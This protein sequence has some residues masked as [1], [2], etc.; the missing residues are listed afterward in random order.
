MV[1]QAIES[2]TDSVLAERLFRQALAQAPDEMEIYVA[3]YKFYFYQKRLAQAET[4]A[5]QTLRKVSALTGLPDDWRKLAAD[6]AGWSDPDSPV[7]YYLY[8]M[9]ALA[10]IA[11]RRE[12]VTLAQSI[13]DKLAELDPQDRVGG[14]VIMD[15]A[16]RM[17]EVDD[18]A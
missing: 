11:L 14:S 8:T 10:F 7:R 1:Q 12:D 17:S 9:K 13:L 3:F 4:I 6:D 16:Q 5:L 18:A 15:L 2:Y